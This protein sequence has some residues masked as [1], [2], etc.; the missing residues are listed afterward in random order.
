MLLVVEPFA[1]G[2]PVHHSLMTSCDSLAF[3]LQAYDQHLNMILGDVE[4]TVT[5]IEI[6]EE[7]YEEINKVSHAVLFITLK[8]SVF[9]IQQLNIYLQ[10]ACDVLA[11]IY[12]LDRVWNLPSKLLRKE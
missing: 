1:C 4:E 5:T 9:I 10:K 12:G 8:M 2:K 11:L 3:P 7:T 6:D